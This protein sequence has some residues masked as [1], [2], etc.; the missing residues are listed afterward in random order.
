MAELQAA[1][2]RCL[3][4][5]KKPNNLWLFGMCRKPTLKIPGV[6]VPRQRYLKAEFGIIL[7]LDA[8]IELRADSRHDRVID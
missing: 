2:W 7:R 1:I 5:D 6:R 8:M 3:R 4:H